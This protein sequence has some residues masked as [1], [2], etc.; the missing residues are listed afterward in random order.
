MRSARPSRYS[1]RWT[2]RG[3]GRQG[4]AATSGRSTSRPW[5]TYSWGGAWTVSSPTDPGSCELGSVGRSRRLFLF[6][7]LVPAEAGGHGGQVTRHALE[8]VLAAHT[9][10]HL[11]HGHE[12]GGRNGL[13]ALLADSVLAATKPLER[14]GQAIGALNQQAPRGE[15]HFAILVDLDHVH[16]VRQ[17]IG[18]TKRVHRI[19]GR[20]RPA[21]VADAL[22]CPRQFCFQPALDVFHVGLPLRRFAPRLPRPGLASLVASRMPPGFMERDAGESRLFGL[23]DSLIGGRRANCPYCGRKIVTRTAKF[24]NLWPFGPA[25]KPYNNSGGRTEEAP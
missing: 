21:H 17:L 10:H 13:L 12:T 11:G 3:S 22:R 5:R 2:S 15:V 18:V 23:K 8:A 6:L 9:G 20:G 14:L 24:W 4:L 25:L 7:E 19:D 1:R 16:L